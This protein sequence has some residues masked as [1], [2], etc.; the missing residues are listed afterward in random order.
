M[1]N[2]KSHIFKEHKESEN[3][4]ILKVITKFPEKWILVDT[5]TLKI[6]NGSK[7][8]DPFKN[9]NLI[10]DKNIFNKLVDTDSVARVETAMTERAASVPAPLVSRVVI[11][12]SVEVPLED[13]AVPASA[14]AADP[15]KITELLVAPLTNPD[16]EF[17]WSVPA[18]KVPPVEAPVSPFCVF[19]AVLSM[20]V[21][22]RFENAFAS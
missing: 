1:K 21:V 14:T 9:W 15:V 6:Y 7:N 3:A 13:E 10:D 4:I 16:N 11:N 22:L 20:P 19:A 12:T 18:V 2:R 17:A 5:E 8:E